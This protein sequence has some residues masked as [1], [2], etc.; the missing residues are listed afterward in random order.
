MVTAVV[1]APVSTA[2]L[3]PTR[4]AL[5]SLMRDARWE[6]RA[7]AVVRLAQRPDSVE[8]ARAAA[9]LDPDPAVLAWARYALAGGTAVDGA[10]LGR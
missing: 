10:P 4:S 6:S 8:V 5:T 3:G 9:R 2:R 7:W 1:V